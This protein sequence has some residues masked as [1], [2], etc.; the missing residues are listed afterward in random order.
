MKIAVL[1]PTH[2]HVYNAKQAKRID[3]TRYFGLKVIIN[4]IAQQFD[5]KIDII[6][7]E[8]VHNYDVILFSCL[9]P[10]DFFALVYTREK[11]I[12]SEIKNIWIAGGP[13]ITNINPFV[14]YFDYIVLGRGE[15]IIN[16][17]LL[18]IEAGKVFSH[19]SVVYTPD[20][21]QENLYYQ[22]YA[23]KL[24]PHKLDGIKEE[25]YGCKYNCTYCRYRTA[26]LPPTMR[27]F[28]T[29]TTMPGNEET[30][31]D[32]DIKNGSFHTSSLD[33]LTEKERFAVLKPIK[34]K[35]VVKGFEKWA[36]QTKKINLKLYFI[37]GF[38]YVGKSNFNELMEIFEEAEKVCQGVDVFLK[39]HFTPMGADPA[40]AGQWEQVDIDTNYREY[41]DSHIP[42]SRLL[43]EKNNF[44]VVLQNSTMRELSLLKRMVFARAELSDNYLI[45]YLASDREQ[46]SHDS[47]QT[48]KMFLVKKRFDISHF[49]EEKEI[50]SYLPSQNIVVWKS[51][52]QMSKEATRM[53]QKLK[54]II[55][56]DEK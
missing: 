18:T 49:I 11:K 27:D 44:R 20:Y 39:L 12:K 52:E 40:T 14:P 33:G 53:R 10:D 9:S 35:A 13:A 25:M 47:N 23:K 34:N 29:N 19:K 17:L 21:K 6:T 51:I 26:T 22:N 28:D 41:L 8:D 43:F 50:G 1:M 24:Y 5:D 31:W 3:I 45:K 42:S 2:V 46:T 55:L 38:P 37:I 48:K 4:E 30:F 56:Q 15:D 7:F 54:D 32:L 16:P 36:T